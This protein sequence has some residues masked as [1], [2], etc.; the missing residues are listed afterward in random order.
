MDVESM[1]IL[2]V[3]QSTSSTYN[4]RLR[5]ESTLIG[6]CRQ[7]GVDLVCACLFDCVRDQIYGFPNLF[8]VSRVVSVESR[9]LFYSRNKFVV[10]RCADYGFRALSTISPDIVSL[11]TSLRIEVN[12]AVTTFAWKNA[13]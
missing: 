1:L 13:H 5:F 11:F 12:T 6:P 9:K 2:K 3:L 10:H 8:L 4:G 7:R